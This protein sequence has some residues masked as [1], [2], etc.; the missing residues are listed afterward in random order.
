[1]EKMTAQELTDQIFDTLMGNVGFSPAHVPFAL[2]RVTNQECDARQGVI[3]MEI[4][5][6]VFRI[7][8]ECE[9]D[10]SYFKQE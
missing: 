6:S 7:T 8:V 9:I 3:L 1:M 2:D 4:D 5:G 10:G